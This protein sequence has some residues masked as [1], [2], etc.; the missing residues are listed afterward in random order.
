ML[1][2]FWRWIVERTKTINLG[3]ALATR[4]AAH[5]QALLDAYDDPD[6]A[7]VRRIQEAFAAG[8]REW[9]HRLEAIFGEAEAHRVLSMLGKEI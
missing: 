5:Q 3:Q 9:K 2:G 8:D 6:P 7:E 4:D 1:V